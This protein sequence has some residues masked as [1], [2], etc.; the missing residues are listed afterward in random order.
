MARDAK[1]KALAK[2]GYDLDA[3]LG[4]EPLVRGG[5]FRSVTV[6]VPIDGRLTTP[7]PRALASGFVTAR[8]TVDVEGDAVR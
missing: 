7:T 6:T 4:T 8:S 2:A 1:K 5:I 3:I